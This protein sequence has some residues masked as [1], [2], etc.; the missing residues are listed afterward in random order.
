MYTDKVAASDPVWWDQPAAKVAMLAC[1]MI[2]FFSIIS[3][4]WLYGQGYIDARGKVSTMSFMS[5][6]YSI[7]FS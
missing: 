4:F 3:L 2:T 1:L 7:I 6:T 5:T